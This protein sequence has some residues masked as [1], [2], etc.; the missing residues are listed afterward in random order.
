[1]GYT[2]IKHEKYEP[3]VVAT[4]L[5]MLT[6]AQKIN[7]PRL[8][9]VYVNELA[10][11]PKTDDIAQLDDYQDYINEETTI[12]KIFVYHYNQKSSDKFFLHIS[13]ETLQEAKNR[14][15]SGIVPVKTESELKEKWEKDRH[16]EALKE[17]NLQLRTQLEIEKEA[18]LKAA[19]ETKLIREKRDREFKQK[20]ADALEGILESEYVK[21]NLPL[22]GIIKQ[23]FGGQAFNPDENLSG[24]G[25]PDEVV[26]EEEIEEINQRTLTIEEEKHLLLL[27]DI[28]AKV[29]TTHLAS[30]MYLLD[31]FATNP[32]SIESAI[33]VVKNYIAR[34]PQT[35]PD[36]ETEVE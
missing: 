6:N 27:K 34:K 9:E 20:A 31:L 30:I 29:G 12:I 36:T 14:E 8:F 7:Q 19:R 25:N 16:Y 32:N 4:I 15:L 10:V 35:V 23:F 18:A 3:K 33:K 1:M 5:L 22:A 26:E 21:K 11:V 24:D 17:E 28:K 2:S 13:P